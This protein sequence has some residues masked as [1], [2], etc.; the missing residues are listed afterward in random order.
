LEN[1]VS[2]IPK[3]IAAA[4]KQYFQATGKGNLRIKIPNSKTTTSILLTDVLY[5][6]TMGLMLVS[7]SKLADAS[8]PLFFGQRCQIFDVKKKVVGE[9]P[10]RNGL[11]RVDH[12]VEGGEMG[13]LAKEVLTVEELHRCMGHI[14]P[15]AAKRMISERSVEG[16]EL[17]NSSEL[18]SCDSCKY[19]KATRKPIKKSR[20]K[21][22]A[23][24]FG[25]EIHSDLWGPSPVQTPGKKEYY[26]TFTDDH[27]RW[28]HLN[29]LQK[30]DK[31]F[32][33]YKQ[34]EAWAKTQIGVRSI[35]RLRSDHRGEY[36]GDEFSNHLAENGTTHILTTHDTPEYNSVSERLNQTLLECT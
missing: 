11:Y 18:K 13:G 36:L 30:K 34:F 25:E 6:P 5:C 35:K 33:S 31:T 14:A 10:W 27:I 8:H 3:S 2:I 17:D 19:A 24:K 16:I 12:S 9:V 21:P 28:T 1:Y 32:N 4:D 15:E 7:I 22:R 20:E 29:L 26:A 23:S